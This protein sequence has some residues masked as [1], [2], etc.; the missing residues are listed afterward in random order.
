M[1]KKTEPE[2]KKK[3]FVIYTRCSTDEQAQ[4]DF[5]TLD[6]QAYHCRNMLDA[7]GYKL[8]D[9][10]E[11]G[12]V[13]DDGYSGKDL[14]RPG[15][16]M[17]LESIEKKRPFDGII[18]FRLD[19]LTRNPRD[20]Y[21]LID[22]FRDKNVE[23]VSVRE[24]LDSSTAIGRVVIGIL[25]L[26]SAFE[27][28]LTGERV[29]ASAIAKIKQGKRIGGKT[30]L[31]YKLVPNGEPLSNGR[32]PKKVV[33]DKNIA[34]HLHIVWEMAAENRSLTAIAHELA[35]RGITTSNGKYWRRQGLS[36]IV[37]NPFYKGYLKYD[38]EI[39]KGEHKPIVDEKLWEKAN[40]VLK[41]RLPGHNFQ[42]KPKQY[43]FLLSGLLVCDE[44]GSHLICCHAGGRD[45]KKFFYYECP[46]SRQRLGC[47]LK[48]ISA[49]AFDK[50]LIN[51]LKRASQDQE[52]ITRAI[53]SA[54]LEA[55]DKLDTINKKIKE[56]EAKLGAGKFETQKLLEL[57]ME[58]TVP[59]GKTFKERM[60]KIEVETGRIEVKLDR[61]QAEQRITQANASSG[62]FLHQNIRF[63][64]QSI[65]KVSAD[66]QKSF[67]RAL[68]KNIVVYETK[69]ALNMFVSG[70]IE[71]NSL[72]A[73]GTQKGERLTQKDEALS[74]D[75]SVSPSC[76]V[77]GG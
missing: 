47:T 17:L 40:K 31:G 60:A 28:E 50:A 22:L 32:Q 19:R 20:L 26:L 51:Y 16:K 45:N 63:A 38:G 7:F 57:A 36:L 58:G 30:P 49:T 14:K 1:T 55:Q 13:K 6:A 27:R 53:G 43:A 70:P 69:I 77:W 11:K 71:T 34:S 62:E 64:I 66:T 21:S 23:F 37:K 54:I 18:F 10:G 52:I 68:I 76:Q 39:Y 8:A 73:A 56:C 2:K 15:I 3:K 41:A 12:I 33:L 65:D 29:K 25:G 74:P 42:P 5:T 59:Q 24:N 75:E 4:G 48:R 61:L 72:I 44:C 35:R 67:I 9:I 46:R